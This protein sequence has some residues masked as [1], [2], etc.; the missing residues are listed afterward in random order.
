MFAISLLAIYMREWRLRRHS[1]GAVCK[2]K[3]GRTL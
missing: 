1:E 2:E 3:Q